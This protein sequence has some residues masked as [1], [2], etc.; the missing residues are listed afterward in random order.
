[1]DAE[2]SWK[3]IADERRNIADLLEGLT[4]EQW[5]TASLAEGWRV[6]DVAAHLAMAPQ[7]PTAATMV[8]EGIRARG[9]FDRMNHDT[10]VRYAATHSPEQ[11]VDELR[12]HAD[13][14]RLPAVTNY[15]NI[16]FDIL[17]H[18][19]DIARPLGIDHPMPLEAARAGADRVWTMGWPFWAK[20]RLKGHRLLAT[21]IDWA[22]GAGEEIREPIA[23]LLLRLTGRG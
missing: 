3:V 8:R 21:D 13:S 9:S 5:D 17:V 18:E 22:V 7:P 10:A 11:I 2:Q 4:E 12:L 20:R 6:H 15:R 23:E 16:L 19:Q 1:M 14:R